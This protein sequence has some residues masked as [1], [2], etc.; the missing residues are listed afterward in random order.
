M[1]A[2]DGMFWANNSTQQ[3]HILYYFYELGLSHVNL[4]NP[5][6]GPKSYCISFL[7]SSSVSFTLPMQEFQ[8]V[9]FSLPSHI[10]TF[11]PLFIFVEYFYFNSHF[12][13]SF[14]FKLYIFILFIFFN[15]YIPL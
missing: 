14:R 3:S 7:L 13:L 5:S 11:F 9:F 6:I 12:L 2:Q 4:F 10:L 15:S 8:I 1:W